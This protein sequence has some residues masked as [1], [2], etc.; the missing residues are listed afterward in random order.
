M[1]EQIHAVDNK[2]YCTLVSL[3]P[4]PF[5]EEKPGLLPPRYMM[6]ASE[7]FEPSV[8][9]LT[10]VRFYVYLDEF[11][12]SIAVFV[13]PQKLAES[14]VNDYVKAQLAY[15]PETGPALFWVL[16][17][18]SPAEVKLKYKDRIEFAKK[19]QQQWFLDLARIADNDFAKYKQHNVVSEMQRVAARLIGWNP[20]EHPWMSPETIDAPVRCPACSTSVAP[21]VV[22]CPNCKCV[23]KKEEFAKLQFA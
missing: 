11:R 10:E 15:T 22:I 1:A 9:H 19:S 21:N 14:L 17:K 20:D 6:D 3:S 18:L 2:T 16:G 4:F 5:C 7:N 12:G 13:S 23:L 8:L